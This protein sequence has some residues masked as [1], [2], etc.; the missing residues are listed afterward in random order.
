VRPSRHTTVWPR[1]RILKA[2]SLMGAGSA[3]FGRALVTLAENKPEV[4]AGMIRHAEW[5]SGLEFSAADRKL[6]LDG[7]NEILQD[8]AK[9]REVPIDNGVAPAMRFDPAPNAPA[10]SA[11]TSVAMSDTAPVERPSSDEDLAFAPVTHLSRLIRDKKI[12]S[13]ELTRFYLDRL[14]CFDP[15]L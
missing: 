1:R 9:L 13:V 11:K 5:I 14:R 4:T 10:K 8:F 12:S 2:I 7:V 15:T 3:V 6:M